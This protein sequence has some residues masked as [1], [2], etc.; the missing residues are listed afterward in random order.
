MNFS[1]T[2][3]FSLT[4]AVSYTINSLYIRSDVNSDGITSPTSISRSLKNIK[5]LFKTLFCPFFKN[6]FFQ[7]HE[8][9]DVLKEDLAILLL[10]IPNT[11]FPEQLHTIIQIHQDFQC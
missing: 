3:Y 7:L 1:F 11:D 9:Y 6:D 4:W 8:H 5:K 10:W 2:R